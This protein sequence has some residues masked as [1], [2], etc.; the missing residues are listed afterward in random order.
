M[1]VVQLEKNRGEPPVF[2]DIRNVDLRIGETIMRHNENVMVLAWRDKQTVKMVT[3]FHQNNIERVEEWQRGHQ[4][5]VAK[6]KPACIVEYNHDMNGV[7]KLNQNIV[8]YPFIRKSRKW[9]KK[10]VMY[11]FQ[12]SLFNAHRVIVTLFSHSSRVL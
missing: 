6:Q 1:Y 8:Y 4:E 2:R 10:F 9:T 5:K 12:I 11:L 7:D 3:T